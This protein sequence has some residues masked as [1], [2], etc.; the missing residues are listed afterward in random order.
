M[1]FV[2]AMAVLVLGG[3]ASVSK[4]E[5]QSGDWYDIGVRDGANGYGEERFLDNAKACAKHGLPADRERWSAGRQH[6][7]ERYCTPRNGF[8]VGAQNAG[9]AGVCPGPNED[10]FL[11][12]YNLGR[13]LADARGR[14]G[15]FDHEI[16]E[17]HEKLDPHTDNNSDSNS[18]D[19]KPLSDAERIELAVSLG[20]YLVKRE[21]AQRDVEELEARGREL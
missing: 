17:I 13:D 2:C 8:A 11:H 10:G 20:V 16:H 19:E 7:L 1:R 5:C 18:K 21:Q 6:G 15:H 3:C 12:G 9:Y 14:L 4:S